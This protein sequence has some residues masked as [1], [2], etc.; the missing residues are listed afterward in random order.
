MHTIQVK[1]RNYSKNFRPDFFGLGQSTRIYRHALLNV[2]VNLDLN[3]SGI[4]PAIGDQGASL[5][6]IP[7]TPPFIEV[8]L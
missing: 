5:Y 8:V 1:Y 2:V 4:F 3:L 6:L 7:S